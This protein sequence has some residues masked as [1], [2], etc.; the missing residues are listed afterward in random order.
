MT[1]TKK[2]QKNQK[3][4]KQTPSPQ[5]NKDP[6]QTNPQNH[7]TATV[8]L[9]PYLTRGI[10]TFPTS[11]TCPWHQPRGSSSPA[12]A[13]LWIRSGR[14]RHGT[15]PNHSHSPLQ[16][17]LNLHLYVTQSVSMSWILF[18]PGSQLQGRSVNLG[19]RA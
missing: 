1:R 9:M 12:A 15:V 6:R 10:P 5:Q 11:R 18:F 2:P 8:K 13:L 4:Q 19:V 17:G 16:V 7:F 3:T 14:S